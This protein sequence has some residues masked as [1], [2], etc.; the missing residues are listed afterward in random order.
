[1]ERGSVF[2]NDDWQGGG[3]L[4]AP[5]HSFSYRRAPTIARGSGVKAGT[6][7]RFRA[8]LALMRLVFTSVDRL[9][10]RNFPEGSLFCS[11]ESEE[12]TW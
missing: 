9:M 1:V 7:G 2:V 8:G 4:T 5:R 10:R 11:A 6:P 12:R 3:V